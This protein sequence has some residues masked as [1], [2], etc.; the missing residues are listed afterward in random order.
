MI[1]EDVWQIMLNMSFDNI[2]FS[3]F[4]KEFKQSTEKYFQAILDKNE[5]DIDF[6]FHEYGPI[7]ESYK[8]GLTIS[9]NENLEEF[10]IDT[11]ETAFIQFIYANMDFNFSISRFTGEDPKWNQRRYFLKEC[12]EISDNHSF[13]T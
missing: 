10:I 1:R 2:N 4:L 7:K 11:A 13:V 12:F 9:S 8:F 5:I 6:S 3:S